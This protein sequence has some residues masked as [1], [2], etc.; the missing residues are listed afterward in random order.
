L[1]ILECN[2]EE[3][4]TFVTEVRNGGIWSNLNN[5]NDVRKV[6]FKYFPEAVFYEEV[7]IDTILEE[8]SSYS[9]EHSLSRAYQVDSE[10]VYYTLL[11]YFLNE[12][13]SN[14]TGFHPRLPHMIGE[15][16]VYVNITGTIELKNSFG[17]LNAELYPLLGYFCW[18]GIVYTVIGAVWMF[19][20]VKH[21]DQVISLHYFITLIY[22]L[23]FFE[24][25]IMYFEYNFLNN[26]GYR[27]T[28]F[29]V[30]NILFSAS[31][32]TL[33]RVLLLAVS[34]GQGI[35]TPSISRYHTQIA[36]ISFLYFVSNMA[37]MGVLFLSNHQKISISLSLVVSVP[38]AITNGIFFY[39]ILAAL[40]RTILFL[41]EQNQ[42]LKFSIM[43]KIII[44]MYCLVVLAVAVTLAMI[45][46]R[47]KTDRDD[48]WRFEWMFSVPYFT[49]FTVYL[50]W[51][52]VILRPSYRSKMLATLEQLRESVISEQ[53]VGGNTSIE[54]RTPKENKDRP[55]QQEIQYDV[56]EN[57]DSNRDDNAIKDSEGKPSSSPN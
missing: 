17:Y 48:N 22:I 5:L 3:L 1:F 33:A 44:A 9:V 2:H 35:T 43:K 32:N 50:V 42:T 8:G 4:D 57:F 53:N 18:T 41:K 12:D 37:Y 46:A 15:D 45:I 14:N 19:F 24:C 34:L 55:N 25:F 20:V 13:N 51:I 39:W 16:D 26:R 30:M 11:F 56:Y 10:D 38:I 47:V 28:F 36:V 23:C 54:M 40:D 49:L 6:L 27:N 29:L 7:E 31:R 52:M 21:F